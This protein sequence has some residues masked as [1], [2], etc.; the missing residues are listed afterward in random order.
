MTGSTKTRYSIPRSEELNSMLHVELG[1]ENFYQNICQTLNSDF[2]PNIIIFQDWWFV[3]LF[4]L[5][6]Y[7]IL[8]FSEFDFCSN[9][10]K[11]DNS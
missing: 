3:C 5:V 7:S 11:L 8:L 1:A 9:W 6:I 4:V 2:F 10:C